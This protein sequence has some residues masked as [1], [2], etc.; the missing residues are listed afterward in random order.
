MQKNLT[1]QAAQTKLV[2]LAH[3]VWKLA[4]VL[5]DVYVVRGRQY[6]CLSSGEQLEEPGI[7]LPLYLNSSHSWPAF[8][9]PCELNH[10][11]CKVMQVGISKLRGSVFCRSFILTDV[12]PGFR[13]GWKPV[14]MEVAD[15][16]TSMAALP[17]DPAHTS[18]WLLE[19]QKGYSVLRR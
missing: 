2:Q 15:R 18:S 6:A 9:V 13:V 10:W 19:L 1:S 16:S 3:L 5:Y 7:H 17:S 11:L 14:Q 4:V 12:R 8:T